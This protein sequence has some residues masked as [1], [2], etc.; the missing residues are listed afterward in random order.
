MTSSEASADKLVMLLSADWFYPFWNQ[1]GLDIDDSK[2]K[3]LQENCRALV[4]ELMANYAEYWLISFAPERIATTYQGLLKSCARLRIPDP[5]S[6]QIREIVEGKQIENRQTR[7]LW[8]LGML[9][10]MAV[11]GSYETG[12]SVLSDDIASIVKK[13]WP[14]EDDDL[15]FDAISDASQTSWDLY[16]RKLTPDL[17]DCLATYLSV[18]LLDTQRFNAYWLSVSK[19]LS[20]DQKQALLNW[21]RISALALAEL[22]VELP[23]WMES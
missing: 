13:N 22:E 17:P 2:R 6:S 19:Q 12:V 11:K 4:R 5:Q 9:T 23:S 16:L 3:K 14:S 20:K 18:E 8:L 21:Y 15:D 7:T 1:V 10:R